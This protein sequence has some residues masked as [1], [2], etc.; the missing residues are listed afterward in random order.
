MALDSNRTVRHLCCSYSIW[1]PALFRVDLPPNPDFRGPEHRCESTTRNIPELGISEN[2][3][4]LGLQG[5]LDVQ[6]FADARNR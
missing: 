5:S 2:K 4:H 1:M 6:V 3:V